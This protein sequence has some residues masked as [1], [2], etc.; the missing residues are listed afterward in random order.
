MDTDKTFITLGNEMLIA[1]K[2]DESELLVIDPTI[3]TI[4]Y[5]L[6]VTRISEF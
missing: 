4:F 5:K 6:Q 1:G 3:H 2:D